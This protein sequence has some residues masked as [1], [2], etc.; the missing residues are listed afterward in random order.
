MQNEKHVLYI[1]LLFLI[2]IPPLPQKM[3]VYSQDDKSFYKYL[4][5]SYNTFTEIFMIT[6]KTLAKTVITSRI[7]CVEFR[8]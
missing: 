4:T 7:F 2:Q 1:E 3:L 8:E 5:E 6:I